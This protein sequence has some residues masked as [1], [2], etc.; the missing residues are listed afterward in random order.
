MAL[1]RTALRRMS[2]KVPLSSWT[3]SFSSISTDSPLEVINSATESLQSFT[4]RL[5]ELSDTI[6]SD[7]T[8]PSGQV[9]TM[10]D[11]VLHSRDAEPS[12][13]YAP[14]AQDARA[15]VLPIAEI[16]EKEMKDMASMYETNILKQM[17][18][19]TRICKDTPCGGATWEVDFNSSS[20]RI[21]VE[22]KDTPCG[23]L[24]NA[25]VAF[26]EVS[27]ETKTQVALGS[28]A[29]VLLRMAKEFDAPLA[30]LQKKNGEEMK[31]MKEIFA[32][33]RVHTPWIRTDEEYRQYYQI[34]EEM[35]GSTK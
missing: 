20:A 22:G 6:N 32:A 3:S 21:Q 7:I 18:K 35:G 11:I 17:A 28:R 9:V 23:R 4:A 27:F 15:T 29:A 8:L 10:K 5:T 25:S 24:H 14:A 1:L 16:V 2:T 13:F 12:A 34:K 30:E 31:K 26:L 33:E 19:A